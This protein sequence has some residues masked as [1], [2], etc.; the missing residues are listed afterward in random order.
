[1]AQLPWAPSSMFATGTVKRRSLVFEYVAACILLAAIGKLTV[2]RLGPDLGPDARAAAMVASC[3]T[4]VRD[5][6]L[7]QDR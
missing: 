3:C 4:P 6:W 1:M 2:E 7:R 5:R